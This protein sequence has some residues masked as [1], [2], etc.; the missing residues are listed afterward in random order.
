MTTLMPKGHPPDGMA[1]SHPHDGTP[2]G[3]HMAATVEARDTCL[4]ANL[5]CGAW[6]SSDAHFG[7]LDDD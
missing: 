1:Y 2:E 3:I 4:V 6:G 7:G 5:F